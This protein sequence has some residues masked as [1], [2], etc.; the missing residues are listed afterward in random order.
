MK[1]L[2]QKVNKKL[3]T[4]EETKTRLLDWCDSYY[5]PPS[6]FTWILIL[7]I[8]C[9]NCLPLLRDHKTIN[10]SPLSWWPYKRLSF[11]VRNLRQHLD[12]CSCTLVGHL[13]SKHWSRNQCLISNQPGTGEKIVLKGFIQPFHTNLKTL[14]STLKRRSLPVMRELWKIHQ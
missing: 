3:K 13:S 14:I 5:S 11:K 7:L 4:K 9:V 2:L 6:F 8:H 10:E 12:L 1:D